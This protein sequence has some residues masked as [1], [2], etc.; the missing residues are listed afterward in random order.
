M[1][2]VLKALRGKAYIIKFLPNNFL[3]SREFLHL[4]GTSIEDFSK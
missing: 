1:Q 2:S 3:F 4:V